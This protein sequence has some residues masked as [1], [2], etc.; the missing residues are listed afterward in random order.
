M[1]PLF[2]DGALAGTSGGLTSTVS[3]LIDD[4]EKKQ[5]ATL[6]QF[7]IDM[8]L[9]SDWTATLVIRDT[10]ST[11]S[12]YRPTLDQDVKILDNGTRL[13]HGHVVRLEDRPIAAPG[14]GT[15]TT[16]TARATQ[17][18]VDQILVNKTYS[19]GQ[20][21]HAI[22]ADLQTTY[23]AAYGITLDATMGTGATLETQVFE[24]VALRDVLGHL[25]EVTGWVWRITPSDELQ[26]FAAGTK[27]AG[28]SLTAANRLS[29]GAVTWEKSRQKYV[30]S[31]RV[32]YGTDTQIPKT[33]IITGDGVLTEWALDYD[34]VRNADGFIVS[35]GYVTDNG[36]FSPLGI[37]G[38]P[39]VWQFNP[40]GGLNNLAR[41][42][43]LPLGQVATFT[44]TAQFPQTVTVED[45]GEIAA[46]GRF[47]Q[48]FDAP[49]IFDK[50]AA[51]E[52]ATGLL[53]RALAVPQ[54]VRLSTRQGF[55]MPGD[56]ITLTFTDRTVSG[57]HLITQVNVRTIAYG[58]VTYDITGLSGTELQQTWADQL[59][60]AIGGATST[61]S[62]GTISGSVVPNFSGQFDGDVKAHT[63]FIDTTNGYESSLTTYTN[64]S[65][66]GAA[67]VLGRHDQD[68]RWAIVAD[69]DQGSTP[70]TQGRLRFH[71]PRRG[72]SIGAAMQ[73]VE[74][75]ADHYVLLPGEGLAALGGLYLGD[76]AG[77]I[78]GSAP[79]DTIKGIKT[80]D[81]MA[82]G[83]YYE[84]SRNKRLGEWTTVAYASGNFTASNSRTWTVASGDQ[85]TYKYMLIGKTMWLTVTI[86]TSSVSGTCSNLFVAI[87]G[88]FAA[89]TFDQFPCTVFDNSSSTGTP[90]YCQVDTGASLVTIGRLDLAQ[91]SAATDLTYVRIPSIC[92]EVL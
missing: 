72:S 22:V 4:V 53:R 88:G 16:I 89:A 76:Y 31:V 47:A 81:I 9:G 80:A 92:F 84:R 52:L 7:S 29:M 75:N 33:Q 28:Y 11:S 23:L 73:L 30:N 78:T 37:L 27:G 32:R 40:T 43:P 91:F 71:L 65:G 87:P 39:Q 82:T 2:F 86:D 58:L 60:A 18:Y 10:D 54:W 50:N 34:S 69:A 19:A 25:S 46:H 56:Q 38:G 5:L 57:S 66:E 26:F 13:F 45:A 59:K 24:D 51:A 90:G 12:A 15:Q 64:S 14:I 48:L 55:V 21:L 36:I 74:D 77:V 79:D 41:T 8:G 1:F 20:T 44:Y 67:L 85:R 70:G 68:Y 35:A 6:N 83:G 62:S 49:D 3:I 17:Q 61:A 63:G 42:S